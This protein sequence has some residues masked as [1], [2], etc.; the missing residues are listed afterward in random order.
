MDQRGRRGTQKGV[1]VGNPA[2]W[3]VVMPSKKLVGKDTV[4]CREREKKT[5][6]SAWFPVLEKK[7]D[8]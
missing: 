1:C 7:S 8:S 6:K 4:N 5:K 2:E 3:G